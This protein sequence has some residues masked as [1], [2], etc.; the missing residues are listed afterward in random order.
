[1]AALG[2]RG[3]HAPSSPHAA[4]AAVAHRVAE[5]ALTTVSLTPAAV[6]R[7]GIETA[8]AERAR[9][10]RSRELGGELMAP[11]GQ[12]AQWT[13]PVAGV[14]RWV[15][16]GP[17][18]GATVRRGDALLRLV[19]FAPV[20]RDLRAQAAQTVASAQARLDAAE[21]RARRAEGLAQDR[22]GSV[23]AAEEAAADRAVARATLVAA[24]ARRARLTAAPLESDVALTVRATMDGVLRQVF[25]SDGQAVAAGTLLGEVVAREVL[26]ARVP[27]FAGELHEVDPGAAAVLRTRVDE[28]GRAASPVRGPVTADV[29]TATAD[30]YFAVENRDGALRPGMRVLVTVP[31]RAEEDAVTVPVSAA[32]YDLEGGAWVYATTAAGTYARRR[33]ALARTVGARAVI[34]RGLTGGETVVSVG[35]AELYGTEFGAGH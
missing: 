7:L 26:W 10:P 21:A 28:A 34:T 25:V 5:A 20:D 29:A 30:L 9:V 17:T 1:M 2:C 24:Q 4:P 35:A 31:L 16:G 18:V 15:P 23:R 32:V 13:A 6:A 8:R 12:S 3:P 27:V 14:V 11:P 19:P 22:A 33:V